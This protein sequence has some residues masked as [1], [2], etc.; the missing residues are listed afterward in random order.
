[1]HDGKAAAGHAG[2]TFVGPDAFGNALACRH[3]QL[4]TQI[5]AQALIQ[6]FKALNADHQNAAGQCQGF[7]N[8]L[9]HTVN[10][11]CATWKPCYRIMD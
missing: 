7:C 4:V 10:K 11:K 8:V 2:H 6:N 1:M 3:Q 5:G 9:F